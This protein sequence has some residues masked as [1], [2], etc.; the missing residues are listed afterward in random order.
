MSP[1]NACKGKIDQ[2]FINASGG[3]SQGIF[4]TLCYFSN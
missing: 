1:Q 4:H 3:G 2:K